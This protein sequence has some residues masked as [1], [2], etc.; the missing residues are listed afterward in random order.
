MVGVH[1]GRHA[2]GEQALGR[3]AI[4][5]AVIDHRDLAPPDALGQILGSRTDA[6]DPLHPKLGGPPAP[7]SPEDAHVAPLPARA[8]TRSSR[9]RSTSSRAW[10]R[11][12]ADPPIPASIREISFT[13][14]SSSSSAAPAMVR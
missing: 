2:G 4:E 8:S 12:C 10:R 6:R 7:P 3:D 14:A 5:V 1:D 11:A 13:R 9:E